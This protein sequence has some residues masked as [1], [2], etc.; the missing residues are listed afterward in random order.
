[1][2]LSYKTE[3]PGQRGD[4]MRSFRDFNRD[5]TEPLEEGA[6]RNV[7]AVTLF[8]KIQSLTTQ[9]RRSTD[10]NEKLDLIA[11]QNSYLA[12]MV[13]AMTQFDRKGKGR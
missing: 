8:T 3:E 6:L 11:S 13:W 2:V 7:S 12:A 4:S 5:V 10:A 9:I 1:M